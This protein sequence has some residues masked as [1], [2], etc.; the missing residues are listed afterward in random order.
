MNKITEQDI[1]I[2]FTT[3]PKA[4]T[5]FEIGFAL[6]PESFPT[7]ELIKKVFGTNDLFTIINNCL[8]Y[9]KELELDYSPGEDMEYFNYYSD[10][11]TEKENKFLFEQDF[12]SKYEFNSSK[13]FRNKLKK[14][15][16][17]DLL[18]GPYYI[19]WTTLIIIYNLFDNKARNF[20]LINFILDYSYD[21]VINAYKK[22][23][24]FA[25]FKS[26]D[27]FIDKNLQYVLP[28]CNFKYIN[29]GINKIINSIE[30]PLDTL[31][32][33]IR[34]I[35]LQYALEEE[36]KY[37]P[38]LKDS[39]P[40]EYDNIILKWFNEY[41]WYQFFSISLPFLFEIDI[42]TLKKLLDLLTP[43]SKRKYARI[44]FNG[45][46]QECMDYNLLKVV[47][48]KMSLLQLDNIINKMEE[49]H[50]DKEK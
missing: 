20:E 5:I 8:I 36:T 45:L 39:I 10:M 4:L 48:Q 31:F 19:Y 24:I 43:E 17:T 12:L 3:V 34:F 6:P 25:Q 9:D 50:N 7:N 14:M 40:K 44:I 47:K 29:E 21:I 27:K 23:G 13:K 32:K 26:K 41:Y 2:L 16:L 37:V 38:I 22:Y 42:E 33:I 1:N 18:K 30:I 46:N 35:A 15:N 49:K 28:W 11:I